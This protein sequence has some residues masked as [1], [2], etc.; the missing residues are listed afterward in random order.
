MKATATLTSFALVA[1]TAAACGDRLLVGS[2]P[3]GGGP[4]TGAAGTGIMTGAAGATTTGAA[5]I[6]TGAAGFVT[7]T[8]GIDTGGGG[9]IAPGTGAGGTI[10]PG[11]GAGGSSATRVVTPLEIDGTEAITR[12]ASVLWREPPSVDLVS[13]A[14][15]GRFKTTEDLYGAYRQLLLDARARTGLG[16]FYRWW[17]KL[18]QLKDVKLDPATFPEYTPQL[19][20][21]MEAETETFAVEVTL[22]P[23]GRFDQLMYGQFSYIN[24]RL[25]ALYGVAGVTG[26][27]LRQVP[28]NGD[29]RA[30]LITQ[31]ALQVLNAYPKRNSPSRRGAYMITRF[32]CFEVP[33]PPPDSPP[34]PDTLPPNVTV[35]QGLAKEVGQAAACAACHTLLDGPGLAFET[36]DALGRWRTTDNGLPIDMTNI[37]VYHLQNAAPMRIDGPVSLAFQLTNSERTQECM[38]RQWL[39]YVTGERFDQVDEASVQE[40]TR[41]F[42]ESGFDLKEL[43][44]AVLTSKPFLKR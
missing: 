41:V 9:T 20:A 30:G 2:N 35:R 37:S 7:G 21:A 26:D 23:H 13:Q 40:A 43:I 8:G 29:Q 38:A 34:L 15:T 4:S 6:S 27:V 1:T 44:F 19:M 25:A 32:Q 18:D 12:L 22:M 39:S 14:V 17:L 3:D 33:A 10:A 31:P 24:E 36:F 42:R 11:T 5:G 28:L 16:E